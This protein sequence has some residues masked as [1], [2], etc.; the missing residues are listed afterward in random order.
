MT[1]LCLS[2]QCQGMLWVRGKT[3]AAPRGRWHTISH[4]HGYLSLHIGHPLTPSKHHSV[5]PEVLIHVLIQSHHYR[6]ITTLSVWVA[7]PGCLQKSCGRCLRHCSYCLPHS[8]QESQLDRGDM[9]DQEP[10]RV[11]VVV[12]W[13]SPRCRHS[14]WLSSLHVGRSLQPNGKGASPI[15]WARQFKFSSEYVAAV[16]NCFF[17]FFFSSWLFFE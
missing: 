4:L 15:V 13:P 17:F 3:P 14:A 11:C 10:E 9:S 2:G 5:K 6:E 16:T 12:G 7:G 1:D 8:R